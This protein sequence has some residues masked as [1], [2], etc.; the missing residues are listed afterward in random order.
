MEAPKSCGDCFEKVIRT[1]RPGLASPLIA[2]EPEGPV[3]T[4]PARCTRRPGKTHPPF[5]DNDPHVGRRV[6][7]C[8]EVQ[9]CGSGRAPRGATRIFRSQGHFGSFDLVPIRED[10]SVPRVMPGSR[11]ASAGVTGL[12]ITWTCW[13]VLSLG[14]VGRSGRC[15]R[16]GRRPPLRR[17]GKGSRFGR[18]DHR[19]A[20]RTPVLWGVR[21]GWSRI[22]YWSGEA[23]NRRRRGRT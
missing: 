23:R 6:G 19:A 15:G 20:P 22:I 17:T 8:V 10:R 14:S 21:A 2:S 13:H 1:I 11:L 18:D 7:R 9:V 3:P 4:S 16:I 12:I 5:A